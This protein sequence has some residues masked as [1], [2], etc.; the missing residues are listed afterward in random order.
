MQ[1]IEDPW[2][3]PGA[4]ANGGGHLNQR[5][6]IPAPHDPAPALSARHVRFAGIYCLFAT[7][8]FTA[9]NAYTFQK[10]G[11]LY[12]KLVVVGPVILLLGIW[13]LFDAKAISEDRR[14]GRAGIWIC[15]VVGCAAGLGVMRALTGSYF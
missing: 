11:S 7:A 12:P 6:S 13:A 14:G 10:D 5:I 9:L 1:R 15:L 2:T 3:S 4:S 8:F